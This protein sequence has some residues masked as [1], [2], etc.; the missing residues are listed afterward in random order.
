[1]KKLKN[2]LLSLL[3]VG[4]VVGIAPMSVFADEDKTYDPN[5]PGNSGTE[6][7]I[8]TNPITMSVTIPTKLEFILGSENGLMGEK[9]D[10]LPTLNI[11]NE[12]LAPIKLTCIN[13]SSGTNQTED[14]QVLEFGR[15]DWEL[16]N[17]FD[18]ED[19]DYINFVNVKK[20]GFNI[21]NFIA[22]DD[23]WNMSASLGS[24][25]HE[26][27]SRGIPYIPAGE[28]FVIDSNSTASVNFTSVDRGVF[29]KSVYVAGAYEVVLNFAWATELS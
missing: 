9:E 29:T 5:E 2:L 28:E 22:S 26:A 14:D 11:K 19:V 17:P 15:N 10:V 23:P 1:M 21:E 6:V 27:S 18:D 4:M 13:I 8:Q 16:I 25:Y 7:N 3:C 24:E 20:L 12:S